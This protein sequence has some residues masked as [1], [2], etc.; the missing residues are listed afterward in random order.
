MIR[1]LTQTSWSS[2]VL[3]RL[4]STLRSAKRTMLRQGIGARRRLASQLQTCRRCL[5]MLCT[6]APSASKTCGP[7]WLNSFLRRGIVGISH[8]TL[9]SGSTARVTGA[10]RARLSV[11]PPY[12]LQGGWYLG[13]RTACGTSKFANTQLVWSSNL[14]PLHGSVPSHWPP[15]I[16]CH[17]CLLCNCVGCI[18]SRMMVTGGCGFKTSCVPSI[19]AHP[20][21]LQPCSCIAT[22]RC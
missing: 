7:G 9:Q 8:S 21:S 19:R 17:G 22:R 10:L 12:F 2:T 1:A 20:L 4:A 5:L 15:S 14:D 16:Y 3:T 11:A 18:A 13:L 6:P